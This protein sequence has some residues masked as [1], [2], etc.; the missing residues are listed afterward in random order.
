MKQTIA[1]DMSSRESDTRL[2]LATQAYGMGV[3][4]PDLRRV[5]HAGAPS[6]LEG[7]S[8]MND[9]NDKI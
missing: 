8:G 2:L 4:T 6:A 9:M 1:H 3:D 7:K 5:I